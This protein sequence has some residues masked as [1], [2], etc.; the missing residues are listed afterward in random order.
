MELLRF[1]D[2]D[3]FRR[4]TITLLKAAATSGFLKRG[5]YLL[6]RSIPSADRTNAQ[7]LFTLS[8]RGG[9]ANGE[10][11]RPFPLDTPGRG[12]LGKYISGGAKFVQG[13]V[14]SSW[15]VESPPQTGEGLHAMGTKLPASEPGAPA[16]KD[17]T[18][19]QRGLAT[20][21]AESEVKRSPGIWG[22]G[23]LS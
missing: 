12:R 9:V 5:R 22:V 10:K 3:H 6:G 8:Q 21:P 19:V 15:R 13:Q 2:G 17:T 11:W 18:P 4:Q 20:P 14:P 1:D 7:R 23:S 16:G